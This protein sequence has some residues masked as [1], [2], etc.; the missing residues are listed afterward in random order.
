MALNICY[1]ELR[2][3]KRRGE[4]SLDEPDDEEHSGFELEA[5]GPAPDSQLVES[6]RAEAVLSR[7][8][9]RLE[10]VA[11]E[12]GELRLEIPFVCLDCRAR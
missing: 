4:F 7:L 11:A 3:L 5:D 9:Q 12:R 2:K 8:G 10:R 1:D 6:E